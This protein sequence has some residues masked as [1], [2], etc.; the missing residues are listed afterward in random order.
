MTRY[1]AKITAAMLI[2][3]LC[4][5]AGFAQTQVS[6]SGDAGMSL[7]LLAPSARIAAL[8]SGGFALYAGSSSLWSNPSSITLAGEHTAEFTHTEWIEGI[9]HEFAS[10]VARTGR[11][12]VGMSIQ[13]FDSGDIDGRASN[14]AY[15]GAYSI[16]TA[17]VSAVYAVPVG[18]RL[19]VGIT[20]RSLYQKVAEETAG[21]YAFD[22]GLMVTTPIEGLRFGAVARNYGRMNKLLDERTKL[23][24]NIGIGG[25][26]T[27][28][29]P[30]YLRQYTVL[31][32]FIFP[33]YGNNGMRVGFEV[34]ALEHFVLR[35]GYRD[36]SYFEDMIYGIG[37][38][39]ARV[40]ADIA[41]SP[42]NAVSD[43]ALRFTLAVTGF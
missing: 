37:F 14:S 20:A 34:N 43:D 33:R 29:L 9:T 31:A 5:L 28:I 1:R 8:G 41:Y 15:T 4:P 38:S 3:C 22:A 11:E 24:E 6:E 10:F 32:D 13:L 42:M 21:G 2:C 17:G 36:D 23:P 27:G 39:W 7:L 12:T 18:D 30:R 40:A 35:L 26:Y 19:S 25:A 16:T